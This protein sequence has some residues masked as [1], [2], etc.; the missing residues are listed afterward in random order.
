VPGSS[1]QTRCAGAAAFLL[2]LLAVDAAAQDAYVR[3]AREHDRPR[4]LHEAVVLPAPD[5]AQAVI[6]FR[7]PNSLLTFVQQEERFVA[8][9]AVRIELYRGDTKID[10]TTWQGVHEAATFAATQDNTRDVQGRVLFD[11]PPG[12]FAY[13]LSLA[14]GIAGVL[15]TGVRT[16]FAVP[17]FGRAIIGSPFF[18][19][20]EGG[21]DGG[22]RVVP[23]NLSGSVPFGERMTALI[24]ARALGPGY[25]IAYRL[26]LLDAGRDRSL[27]Q[28]AEDYA[29]REGDERIGEGRVPADDAVAVG[30][31]EASCMCWRPALETSGRLV[32][33]AFGSE[34]LEGGSYVL[35]LELTRS[36]GS[37]HEVRTVF[38]TLWRDMP[39]S[40]YDVDVAIRN[41]QYI[42]ER[43]VLREMR[44]GTQAA[45]I[46]RFRAYWEA[47]DPSPETPFN[48][49]MAEY[50]RR[51]DIAADR[52][53]TGTVPYPDGLRTD[54]ANVYILHG[55][56][57]D[58]DSSLP[59]D[60]GVIQVWTYP[61]GRQFVFWAASSLDALELREERGGAQPG[62][63]S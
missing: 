19:R 50:Y 20:I 60:G 41:L 30:R 48:E 54:A 28:L 53:R 37:T 21:P 22:A 59:S 8:R 15:G 56:P 2:L 31:V 57:A 52:F 27:A 6:A 45:R 55:P 39:L 44:R 29:G 23:A 38:Q 36:D 58:I 35:D 3:V 9:P 25:E 14:D 7:V 63:G 43:D 49:L 32:P 1:S 5:G 10:E 26:S 46:E 17:D 18:G 4:V 40:L 62:G 11:L 33:I 16:P 42:E 12:E 13:R 51:I 34:M 47:R 24:P 61:N